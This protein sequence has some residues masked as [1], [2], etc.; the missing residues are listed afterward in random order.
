MTDTH[1]V[2]ADRDSLV[3]LMSVS[4]SCAL[5]QF[6][7]SPAFGCHFSDWQERRFVSSE[8]IQFY[9]KADN[10]CSCF[11]REMVLVQQK[12][13]MTHKISPSSAKGH[14][15]PSKSKLHVTAYSFIHST[16]KFSLQVIGFPNSVIQEFLLKQT[17]KKASPVSNG[18]KKCR[19]EKT[20]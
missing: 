12:E 13:K 9:G 20:K 10:S 3:F 14:P 5:E 16:N 11:L 2:C 4:D 18:S 7:Q 19:D 6:C 1:W 15:P 17:N 8:R